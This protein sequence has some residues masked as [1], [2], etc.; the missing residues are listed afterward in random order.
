MN[1][2]RRRQR[3]RVIREMDTVLEACQRGVRVLEV[4]FF[5]NT[6]G[7]IDH[8]PWRYSAFVDVGSGEI[9]VPRDSERRF[10]RKTPGLLGPGEAFW[11]DYPRE[12]SE[13]DEVMKQTVRSFLFALVPALAIS[14]S[15]CAAPGSSNTGT[16]LQP[17]AGT[18]SGDYKRLQGSWTV[19]SN[20]IK[21]QA[22]PQMAGAVFHFSGDRHWISGD[23]GHEWFALDE[24]SS[25][26]SI[27][28]YDKKTP[29]I[30]GIYKIEGSR[31]T[32]CTAA[33]GQ[34]RPTEFSTSPFSGTILTV[35]ERR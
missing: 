17:Q 18:P 31:L 16:E 9:I 10:S 34:P 6:E 4:H 32:L 14:L 26:K 25:P 20:E 3:D 12:F 23:K 21:K 30:K 29:T 27:D 11:I 22:L 19:T 13:I 33:P 15:S 1:E 28:F 2:I 24:S 8:H 35:T 7:R 5:L